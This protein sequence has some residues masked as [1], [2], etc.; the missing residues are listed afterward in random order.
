MNK[1][2]RSLIVLVAVMVLAMAACAT[3][4]TQTE[5]PTEVKVWKALKVSVSAYDA[6]MLS[7]KDLYASGAIPKESAQKAWD[8]GEAFYLAQ[9]G[10]IAALRTYKEAKTAQSQEALNAAIIKAGGELTKF[11]GLVT[12][13]L[14]KHYIDDLKTAEAGM[15]AK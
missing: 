2:N 3:T 9:K 14:A 6:A 11:I 13:F 10:A 7:L 5:E 1:R 15:K 4:P 8:V 12:P